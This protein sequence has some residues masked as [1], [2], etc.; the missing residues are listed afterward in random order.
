MRRLL[1]PPFLPQFLPQLLLLGLLLP[2]LLTAAPQSHLAHDAGYY[3]LQ[4][5]W[6]EQSDLWVPAVVLGLFDG[7]TWEEAALRSM[8]A[9][10]G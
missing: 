2:L 3:A 1:P 10:A 6:I 7:A 5:R 4:A 8:A 9:S